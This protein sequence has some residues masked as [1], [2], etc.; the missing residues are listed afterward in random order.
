M[1]EIYFAIPGDMHR[2][3]GGFLYEAK[4][5][6]ALQSIGANVKHIQLPVGFPDPSPKEMA[7]TIATLSALPRDSQLI[8]DGLVFGSI[9]PNGLAQVSAAVIA[10]LHHPLGLET[11]LPAER[12]AF[13]IANEKAALERSDHVLVPSPHTAQI[14]QNQFSVAATRITIA[15]PGFDRPAHLHSPSTQEK[16]PH[17]L[18]VG[19][20][21]ERKGHD[22]LLD[23]LSQITDLE[24]QATVAGSAHD[25]E[26]AARLQ[27]QCTQLK[28][29]NR[30]RFAGEVSDEELTSL[31][32]AATIFALATRYEG[33]GIVFGE[34]MLRGLPI[35]SCSTGAVPDTVGDAGLLVPRDDPTAFAK[36]LRSLLEDSKAHAQLSAL[37]HKA[38]H[39]LHQWSDTATIVRD[40]LTNL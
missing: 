39:N 13:L 29:N 4:L 38:G 32:E 24:W 9:D 22:V 10:M 7:D 8:L 12:A 15:P 5:L 36:A 16:P 1:N 14:L 40:A 27:S 21:A 28:L 26:Y 18:S 25:A 33:Y 6:A 2:K 17:I 31:Y 19:L 23:A 30:V 20:L 37:S 35:V 3:T 34:A 11:G